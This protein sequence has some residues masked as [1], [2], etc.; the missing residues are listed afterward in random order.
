[1]SEEIIKSRKPVW[2]ALSE[3]YL[4]CGLEDDDLERI[5][6]V[7]FKSDYNLDEIRLINIY[8]VKPVLHSNLQSTVGSW[9]GFDEEWLLAAI[10][11]RIVD[12]NRVYEKLPGIFLIFRYI[13]SNKYWKQIERIY[14]RLKT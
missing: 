5:A 3:F 11:S 14:Q 13:F 7:F 4:D 6:L 8:E 9:S 1:M 2:I 10:S 12:Y